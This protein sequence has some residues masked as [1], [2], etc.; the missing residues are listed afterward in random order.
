MSRSPGGLLAIVLISASTI[1]SPD[2]SQLS[3]AI[4]ETPPVR[5][6]LAQG[7]EREQK[8]KQTLQQVLAAHDLKK[9]TFTRRVIIEQGAV[10]HA[11]PVLT[12]NARFASSPDELL[13]TYIHEQLHWHLRH[14][15]PQQQ[16]A[17][18][19]LRR[20]YPDAPIGLPE[21]AAN[22]YSTYGHLVNCY[23]EVVALRE[24]LGPERATA[25]I[26]NKGNY[27]WIYATVVR[28]EKKIAA[29]VDRHNLRVS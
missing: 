27:T 21:G 23:L 18:A 16:A 14:R 15:L 6:D 12:L 26:E 11:F 20:M 25:A 4:A 7:T 19:E 28:D 29:V 10:N 24:L 13:S 9:Y 22:A 2:R 1:L 8:T 17:I 3:A 5:I